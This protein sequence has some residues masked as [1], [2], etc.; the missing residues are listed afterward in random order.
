MWPYGHLVDS[1]QTRSSEHQVLTLYW[2]R[3]LSCGTAE[4]QPQALGAP[5]KLQELPAQLSRL[6][7]RVD[8][9]LL[10]AGAPRRA[11]ERKSGRGPTFRNR[12]DEEA[13]EFL[14]IHLRA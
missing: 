3:A 6:R 2:V 12:A 13:G 14:R 4:E 1:L 7:L 8:P 10:P 9:I 5:G 11:T